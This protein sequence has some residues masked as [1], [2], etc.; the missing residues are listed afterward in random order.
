MAEPT[1]PGP[2]LACFPD[3]MWDQ[4]SSCPNHCYGGNVTRWAV[5]PHGA[6]GQ[7][8]SPHPLPGMAPAQLPRGATCPCVRG[9]SMPSL[10]PCR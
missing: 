3:S 9:P 2:A 6:L 10:P 7:Q 5:C 4:V 8:S 1:G